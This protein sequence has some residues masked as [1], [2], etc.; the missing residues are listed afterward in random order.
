[1]ENISEHISYKEATY[2]LT[3]KS[4]G[5]KNEPSAD[6]LKRMKLAA[7]MVFEPVRN[8]FGMPVYVSSFFRCGALNGAIGGSATSSHPRGEALDMDGDVYG[9][10]SNKQIFEFVRDSL[11]FDQLIIEG[12]DDGKMAWVH[13]SYKETGNRNQILFM[14]KVNGKTIYEEYS[15][16]R[17]KELIN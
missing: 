15:D 16:D 10:P 2:S 5:I 13:C 8:H 7:K 11:E 6:V 14:Y 1:M 12:I 9:S 3:A 17:Y 4:K